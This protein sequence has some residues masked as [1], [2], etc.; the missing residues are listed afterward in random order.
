MDMPRK[1]STAIPRG[2][3][4]TT[5]PPPPA[6]PSSTSAVEL[7]NPQPVPVHRVHVDLPDHN[8]SRGLAD[9][10]DK[11]KR[12]KWAL[13]G[14]SWITEAQNYYVIGRDGS[15]VFMQIGYSNLG[16]IADSIAHS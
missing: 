10:Q 14:S 1:P 7:C 6:A 8:D 13:E 4:L 12:F 15:L 2:N 3:I 9:W 11:E 5:A 16:Y